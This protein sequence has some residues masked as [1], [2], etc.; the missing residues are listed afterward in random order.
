M[1]LIISIPAYNE[2]NTI[3]RIIDEINQ[4]MNQTSYEYKILVVNDGSTDNTAQIAK[5]K[6]A[7]VYSNQINLGL[8]G[9]FQIEIEKCLALGADIIV[10]I[11]A[12]GQYPPVFI[13]KLIEKIEQGYDLVLGSRFEIKTNK[14]NMPFM[15]R[16]GNKAFAKVL[17]KLTKKKLTDTTTGFRAFNKK[18]AENIKFINISK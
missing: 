1:N 12:D 13:P 3:G 15:N 6:G 17:S 2:E 11:D 16:L 10:H 18:V 9:T 4:I 14:K 7:L 5:N 8:A